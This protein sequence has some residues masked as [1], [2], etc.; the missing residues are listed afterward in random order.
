MEDLEDARAERKDIEKRRE[1]MVK[2]AKALQNK[3]QQ[4]RTQGNVGQSENVMHFFLFCLILYVPMFLFVF[5][6]LPILGSV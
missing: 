4:R 3:T 1:D 5:A 2:R 6:V